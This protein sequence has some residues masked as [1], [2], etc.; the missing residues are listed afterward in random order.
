MNKRKIM[1]L[2]LSICMVAILAVGGSIAYLTDDDYQENCFT[3]GN[4]AIDLWEDFGDNEDNLEKLLP[5]TGSAQAGTLKNGVEKKVYVDNTG[6]EEAYVRVHIAIPQ[7]LDDGADTFDAGK[8][9]LHFN[10]DPESVADGK[11][12][13]SKG[14]DTQTGDNWNCYEQEI[15]DV[16]YN[17]YVVTYE[18]ALKNGETTVDAMHQVYLDSKVTNED[19]TEIKETLGDKWMIKVFAE[20]CQKEGF[21]DAYEAL[22]TAFG[23]PANGYADNLIWDGNTASH[24]KAF[25]NNN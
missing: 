14:I 19:I 6:S 23:V 10:Y 4:V 11:W 7:I 24:D 2:A 15:N 25:V 13:W 17:V 12:N 5:S 3:V 18:T 9:V 20:A 16:L 21:A 22:N 1:T 8:N